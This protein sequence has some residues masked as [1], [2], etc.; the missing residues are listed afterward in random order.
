MRAIRPAEAAS[1]DGRKYASDTGI[2]TVSEAFIY[3]NSYSARKNIFEFVN[4]IQNPNFLTGNQ[5]LNCQ[6]T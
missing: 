5:S 6:F 3:W 1:G 4:I 2:M